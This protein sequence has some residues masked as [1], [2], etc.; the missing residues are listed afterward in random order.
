MTD[1]GAGE[2]AIAAIRAAN[3]T[4]TWAGWWSDR[5]PH[6][7]GFDRCRAE[8]TM[9]WGVGQFHR[10]CAFIE[11]A[12][13]TARINR[14]HDCYGWKHHAERF[15]RR[16]AA[17]YADYYVGEGMFIAAALALGLSVR[18]S[19]WETHVNLPNRAKIS[20]FTGAEISGL[21]ARMRW[22]IRD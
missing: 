19:R 11:Q 2:A 14:G 3:P 15:A 21:S 20:R 9:A 16:E 4:L 17:D 1:Q 8:M 6:P 10:A 18:R 7:R 5:F 13:R 22:I 12:P